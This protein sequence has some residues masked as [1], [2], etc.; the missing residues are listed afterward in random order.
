[1]SSGVEA[2]KGIKD[3]AKIREFVAAVRA[4]RRCA[5]RVR[6]THAWTGGGPTESRNHAMNTYQQPDASGHFGN[7]GGTLPSETLTHA[8]SELR[9]A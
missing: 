3:A 6:R 4:A 5:L 8:I 1:V 9:D 7:Y 2:S